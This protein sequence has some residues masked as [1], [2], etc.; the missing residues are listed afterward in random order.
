MMG[1]E[2]TASHTHRHLYDL[3]SGPVPTTLMGVLGKGTPLNRLRTIK[4]ANC[5]A[6]PRALSP[7]FLI[8]PTLTIG[9]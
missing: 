1:V 9:T 8:V 5:S 6:S 2:R 7:V 4:D 3:G